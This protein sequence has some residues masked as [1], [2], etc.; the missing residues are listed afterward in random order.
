MTKIVFE[1]KDADGNDLAE[2]LGLQ[3]LT[4]EEAFSLIVSE[5]KKVHNKLMEK[6]GNDKIWTKEKEEYLTK[7]EIAWLTLSNYFARIARE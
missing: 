6:F 1:F 4:F 2:L 7:H 5:S 3:G